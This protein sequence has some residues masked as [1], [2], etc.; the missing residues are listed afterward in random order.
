MAKNFFSKITKKDTFYIALLLTV[1]FT[2]SAY[3]LRYRFLETPT[4]QHLYKTIRN[5]YH[6][7]QERIVKND[8][9]PRPSTVISQDELKDEI[10]SELPILTQTNASDFKKVS[11]LREWVFSRVPTSDSS[12]IINNLSEISPNEIP[13]TERLEI[14]DEGLAGAWCGTTAQ[15]LRDVYEL[16]GFEAYNVNQGNTTIADTHVIT[17]VKIS[18]EDRTLFSVQDSY[19]NYTLVDASD[20]PLDYF[21]ILALLRFRQDDQIHFK[22]GA[23]DGRNQKPYLLK[24]G[25]ESGSVLRTLK[26]GNI[27][28]ERRFDGYFDLLDR[29]ELLLKNHNY[30]QNFIYIYLFPFGLYGEN[31]QK[32]QT[33]LNIARSTSGTWC[34][35]KETC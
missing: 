20:Q 33:L 31:F 8:N 14:F 13:F 18:H 22:W 7:E 35:D 15:T 11:A 25:T 29:T 26:N 16:F 2:F 1:V 9:Y 6:S 21:T 17:I 32:S 30:P 19:L 28:E 10:I 27:I 4:G 23:K 24:K 12:L 5:I 34:K 3:N